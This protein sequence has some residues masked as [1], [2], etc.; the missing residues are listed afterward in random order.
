[1]RFVRRS[2]EG[3]L[4]RTRNGPDRHSYESSV[5]LDTMSNQV[6]HVVRVI[7]VPNFGSAFESAEQSGG[8]QTFFGL[9]VEA[10]KPPPTDVYQPQNT[11]HNPS[12]VHIVYSIF[13][14]LSSKRRV[15]KSSTSA[16]LL[17]TWCILKLVPC[18]SVRVQELAMS[19][20]RAHAS[21]NFQPT[22]ISQQ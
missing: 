21:T 7:T 3:F 15:D 1:M 22:C 13:S 10:L 18:K 20:S 19:S 16:E 5:V 4:P 12:I 17:R 6:I 14:I 9:A 11:N 2:R 8:R